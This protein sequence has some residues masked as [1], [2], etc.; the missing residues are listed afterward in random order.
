[1]APLPCWKSSEALPHA[2]QMQSICW[3]HSMRYCPPHRVLSTFSTMCNKELCSLPVTDHLE[4]KISSNLLLLGSLLLLLW[5]SIFSP[6]S[7]PLSLA[8]HS[9]LPPLQFQSGR[10]WLPNNPAF[11]QPQLSLQKQTLPSTQSYTRTER[12]K[13]QIFTDRLRIQILYERKVLSYI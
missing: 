4:A 11:L 5:I 8:R 10:T 12:S 1:M 2:D 9:H 3:G 7:G 13:K 6:L